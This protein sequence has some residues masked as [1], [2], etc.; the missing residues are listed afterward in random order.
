M[1]KTAIYILLYVTDEP[2][3][4]YQGYG[5]RNVSILACVTFT[6]VIKRGSVSLVVAKF[7]TLKADSEH[8]L[9]LQN[10]D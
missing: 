10:E 3:A 9:P 2:W 6:P 1:T 5:N 7:A 8:T 4:L